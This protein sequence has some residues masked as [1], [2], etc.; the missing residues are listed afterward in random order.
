MVNKQSKRH[1]PFPT[2]NTYI[3]CRVVHLSPK[4]WSISKRGISKDSS[5]FEDDSW[6]SNAHIIDI[7]HF[8]WV[9]PIKWWYKTTTMGFSY[10][11]WWFWGVTWGYHDLRKHPYFTSFHLNLPW[12]QCTSTLSFHRLSGSNLVK[13]LCGQ[14]R[15]IRTAKSG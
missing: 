6:N 4:R 7:D 8:F 3:H 13:S 10:S 9:F 11:K 12:I 14:E 5:L 15:A 1:L 2:G